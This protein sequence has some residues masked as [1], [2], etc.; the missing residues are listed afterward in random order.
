MFRTK[1]AVAATVLATAGSLALTA[2][3][4]NGD[5]SG[6]GS[7]SDIKVL[8][9]GVFKSS[10]ISLPDAELALKA[11]VKQIN[12]AGGI[13]GRK[14][15]L[16]ICDD[17]FDPNKSADC[18][19]QAVSMKAVAVIAPYAYNSQTALPVLEAA[20]IPMVYEH[21]ASDLDGKSS[22]AYPRSAGTPGVY[23]GLGI[24]LAKAGCK[25]VGAIVAAFPAAALGA[26][27]LERGLTAT[28]SDA[29][30]IQEPIA[31]TAADMSVPTA[32]LVKAGVDCIVATTAAETGAQIAKALEATGRTDIKLG[33]V[34]SVFDA[35]ALKTL[36]DA[37]EGTILVGQEYRPTDTDVPA[38]QEA[39]AGLDEYQA[40]AKFSSPFAYGAWDSVKVLGELLGG[41]EGDIAPA[42]VTE[43]LQTFSTEGNLYAPMSFADEAPVAEYPRARNWSYLVWTVSNGE[44]ELQSDSF[45]ELENIE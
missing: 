41:I 36:G 43:A 40:G 39:A 38:V 19:R 3:S 42:S 26:K 17:A 34:S 25:N 33:A 6:S 22:A 21:L 32:K 9:M 45:V 31:A 27:W 44:A 12:D 23:A 13:N 20:K 8:A 1:F 35:A 24:E 11:G 7:K 5:D 14:I 30:L 18:A 15:D 4:S 37:V 2:C 10:V 28:A 16:T 29:K